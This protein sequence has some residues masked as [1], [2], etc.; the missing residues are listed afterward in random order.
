LLKIIREKYPNLQVFMITAYG[1]EEKKRKA[2]EYGA[3]AYFTKPLNFNNLKEK[4]SFGAD[5]LV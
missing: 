5:N 2:E 1:D 4:I 3:S